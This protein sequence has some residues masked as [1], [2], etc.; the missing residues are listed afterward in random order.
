MYSLLLTLCLIPV[1][2]GLDTDIDSDNLSADAN[3]CCKMQTTQLGCLNSGINDNCMWLKNKGIEKKIGERFNS[4][5]LV[6]RFVACKKRDIRADCNNGN[7][8][9]IE[10]VC[11]PTYDTFRSPAHFQVGTNKKIGDI[12]LFDENL[13]VD[14]KFTTTT[15]MQYGFNALLVVGND[16]NAQRFPLIGLYGSSKISGNICV[17]LS[18]LSHC[19]GN[20]FVWELNKHY[21]IQL[22]FKQY[23]YFKIVIN[24]GEDDEYKETGNKWG[25]KEPLLAAHP[26]T[27]PIY[28]SLAQSDPGTN[29]N[30]ATGVIINSLSIK[31]WMIDF[32][33]QEEEQEEQQEQEEELFINNVS[34]NGFSIFDNVTLIYG[35]SLI[36]ILLAGY[37]AVCFYNKKC[38]YKNDNK[39]ISIDDASYI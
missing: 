30:V 10:P 28:T 39:Y 9:G 11:N 31:T 6:R 27:L 18:G 8:T 15:E 33:E 13:E 36:I 3:Y 2:H 21:H 1:V 23:E 14:I 16:Y 5:C 29:P 22:Y 17:A 38:G 12:M 37:G 19:L 32:E 25:D 20:D 7:G 24:K 35:L 4:R 34:S 26:E